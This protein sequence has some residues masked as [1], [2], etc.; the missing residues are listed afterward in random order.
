[1]GVEATLGAA[2]RRG[3]IESDGIVDWIG[4]D[5]SYRLQGR[6]LPWKS[7]CTHSVSR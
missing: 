7:I 4:Q 6:C 2:R 1:M 3:F 5:F